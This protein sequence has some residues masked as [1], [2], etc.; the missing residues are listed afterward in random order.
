MKTQFSYSQCYDIVDEEKADV[1]DNVEVDVETT[2]ATGN[3][4]WGIVTIQVE[5]EKYPI[6]IQGE[7]HVNDWKDEFGIVINFNK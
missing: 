1:I 6:S 5:G 3:V 2:D 4:F 7:H